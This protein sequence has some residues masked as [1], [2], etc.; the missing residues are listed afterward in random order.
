MMY[1]LPLNLAKQ[2]CN[3]NW[4][5]CEYEKRESEA[6]QNLFA[7]RCVNLFPLG[8]RGNRAENEQNQVEV[9]NC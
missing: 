1:R 7:L 4:N 2:C 8:N 6:I 5:V 9:H 3:G